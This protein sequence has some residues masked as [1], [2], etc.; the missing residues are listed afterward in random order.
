MSA[1]V[2]VAWIWWGIISLAAIILTVWDKAIA[3]RGMRRV[4]ERTLMWVGALGGA[5][6]M[7][8]TMKLIRHKTLKPKFMVGLPLL[9]LLHV[10]LVTLV[11]LWHSGALTNI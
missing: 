8:V 10:V 9:I 3:G 6:A 4:P 2:W 1:P 11:W 7:F 5:E